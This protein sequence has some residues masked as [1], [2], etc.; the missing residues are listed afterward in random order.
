M[1]KHCVGIF[2]PSLNEPHSKTST[3]TWGN[4]VQNLSQWCGLVLIGLSTLQRHVYNRSVIHWSVNNFSTQS[5]TAFFG[6]PI[7]YYSLI[8]TFHTTYNNCSFLKET[9]L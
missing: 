2:A 5:Y 4:S 9:V 1:Y 7:C 3:K 6:F 8:H